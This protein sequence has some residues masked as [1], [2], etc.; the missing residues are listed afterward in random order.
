[1]YFNSIDFSVF[2]CLFFFAHKIFSKTVKQRNLTILFFSYVFYAWWDW[3]FLGLIILSSITD[4]TIGNLMTNP[5]YKNQKKT[6]LF[7]SILV[8]IGLLIYFKYFNFF[9]E[10]FVEAFSLFGKDMQINTLKIILPVGISFYTFQTLSYTIDIYRNKIKPTNDI[11]AFFSFVAFFPQLVAGP[12]ERASHLLPQ[13]NKLYKFDYEE[14]KSGMRLVLL[15]LFKKMIIADRAGFFV[16]EFYNNTSTYEGHVYVIATFLFAIQIYCDFSGYSDIAIGIA[17]TIGF[18]LNLNFS[19]PYFSK[20]IT[21]FWRRWH[22]SLSTWFRDYLYIP[23]GGNKLGV[24]RTKLNLMIVF[25]VS[26]LWHGAALN[27][28]IWGFIHGSIIIM[29][30]TLSKY[31]INT[32]IP[33]PLNHIISTLFTFS[34]VCLAWVF[35]RASTFGESMYIIKNMFSYNTDSFTF[36]ENNSSE[37]SILV[38]FIFIL[39]LMEFFHNKLHAIHYFLNAYFP[40]RW[41]WYLLIAVVFLIFG[42]YGDNQVKEFIYFQF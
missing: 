32:F 19:T 16:N 10:S 22:M 39:F 8:N 34:M 5:K 25:V 30:K 6:L 12:I 40:L 31:S 4:F 29:E 35:F 18:N 9:I 36:L 26:G 38:I 13:F 21:E 20:S 28:L 7:F 15:G 11:I 17:R 3:R 27:F 41:S 42:I 14:F 2:F 23:L 24:S 33:K 37:F 1:M